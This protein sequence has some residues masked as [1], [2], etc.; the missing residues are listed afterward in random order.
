MTCSKKRKY[1]LLAWI[2][3]I[4][5][6][7]LTGCSTSEPAEEPTSRIVTDC[8]GREVEIP[9]HVGK[10][11]CIDSF[12]GE[13][14]VMSGAG[15][16]M[17]CCPNG[18]K[19]D[20]LL[21]Q[22]YPDLENV[23]VV[24]SSGSINAE[25]LL[26]L[27]PDVILLKNSFYIASA[28]LDK[29][30]KTMIPYLVIKYSNMEEQIRA[31]RLVGEVAGEPASLKADTIADYY[32]DTIHLVKEKA[33][34]IPDDQKKTVYH[35]INGVTRTDGETS[36]GADW[37]QAVGC[38]NISVGEK[39][40]MEGDVFTAGTE[41][42][43]VWDPD[44]V[45]CN[46]PNITDFFKNG[47]TFA[48]LRAVRTDQVYTIP[49]GATRW[50]QQGSTETFFAMLWLGNTLYPEQYKDI[51]LKQEV[52]DFYSDVL[53]IDLTDEQYDKIMEGKGIRDVSLNSTKR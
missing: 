13:I 10:I 25:A 32:E 20:L 3:I 21:Q 39:L 18:I 23:S 8:V 36:L 26:E 4:C 46:D 12:S 1:T 42:I 44:V 51:D 34:G 19:T 48:G 7:I 29:I 38:K 5:I 14:M 52:F 2:S 33:A 47:D 31:I 43:F 24:Q 15:D 17:V 41:Q 27:D 40:L 16:Q 30:E 11:A 22:I 53:S 6:L 50:G 28:E 37:I 9:Q 49:I 45:I 35:S